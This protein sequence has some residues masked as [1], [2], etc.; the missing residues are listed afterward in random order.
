MLTGGKNVMHQYQLAAFLYTSGRVV[1]LLGYL[2]SR[3]ICE[4]PNDTWLATVK[5]NAGLDLPDPA[6]LLLCCY[7]ILLHSPGSY[8]CVQL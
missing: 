7:D 3:P 8:K 5:E 1:M 4:L 2:L 6:G